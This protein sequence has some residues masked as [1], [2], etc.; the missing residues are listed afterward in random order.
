MVHPIHVFRTSGTVKFTA[1]GNGGKP[2]S[3]SCIRIHEAYGA[4]V[5]GPMIQL[6]TCYPDGF[7]FH[8]DFRFNFTADGRFTADR[9]SC[10]AAKHGRPSTFGP[11]QVRELRFWG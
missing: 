6:Q 11:L 8:P 4:D 5:A 7:K 1:V 3:V 9:G 2:G 10:I